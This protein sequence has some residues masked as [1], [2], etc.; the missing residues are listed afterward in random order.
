MKILSISSILTAFAAILWSSAAA[1]ATLA[2]LE[3]GGDYA[4]I[5]DQQGS[6]LSVTNGTFEGLLFTNDVNT[7]SEMELSLTI[8]IN[9]VS[10]TAS[11]L[12]PPTSLAG[13]YNDLSAL[14]LSDPGAAALANYIVANSGAQ[15]PL[16]GG[17]F[18]SS[19]VLTS[20]TASGFAGTFALGF[21]SQNPLPDLFPQNDSGS[22]NIYAAINDVAAVPIPAALPMLGVALGGLFGLRRTRKA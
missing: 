20:S 1:A 9:G 18:N 10:D 17:L 15:I 14:V 22:F 12:L 13:L 4:V 19:Y 2:S 6:S 8:D 3:I 5:Q 16:F 7:V 11:V 21:V